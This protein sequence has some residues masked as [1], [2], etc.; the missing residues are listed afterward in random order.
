MADLILV[1]GRTMPRDVPENALLTAALAEIGVESEI[2]VWGGGT[3]WQAAALVLIRTPWDYWEHR[4]EFL[5]WADG[6]AAVTA[7]RNPAPLLAWNSHKGYLLDLRAAGVP[8]IRTDL[9]AA[10]SAAGLHAEILAG[11]GGEIVIKPA[12][13]AGGRGA[14]RVRADDPRAAAH[15]AAL[16]GGTAAMPGTDTLVQPFA[17]SVLGRGEVSLVFFEGEYSHAVRKVAADGEYRIHTMYGGS[18][19]P[20]TPTPA[21]LAVARA[22]LAAAPTATTYGRV[23]LV[24]TETGPAVM[25]LELV[26]PE[27]FLAARATATADFAGILGRIVREARRGREGSATAP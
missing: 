9:V 11:H 5:A 21:E 3:A 27:L 7:L 14:L 17:T 8:V 12:V 6:V 4:G 2:R 20:H 18:V 10:E 24:D 22:A 1:T 15:L 26:E 19:L 13:S 16:T 23:D 25:E